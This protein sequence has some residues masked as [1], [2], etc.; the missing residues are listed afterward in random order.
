MAIG[1]RAWGALR[2]IPAQSWACDFYRLQVA[3]SRRLT[4]QRQELAAVEDVGILYCEK[5]PP[6]SKLARLLARRRLGA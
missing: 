4:L 5:P 3:S 6:E 2:A 1:A